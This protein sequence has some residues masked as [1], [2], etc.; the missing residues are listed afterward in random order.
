MVIK[1]PS[2]LPWNNAQL[3]TFLRDKINQLIVNFKI[4]LFKFLIQTGATYAQAIFD[5]KQGSVH[6]AHN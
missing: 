4:H 2:D 5:A 6:R 3:R 1:K